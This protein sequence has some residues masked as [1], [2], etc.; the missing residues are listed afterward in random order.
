MKHQ[1]ESR[2]ENKMRPRLTSRSECPALMRINAQM[3]ALEFI[4]EP[5]RKETRLVY[6]GV[7]SACILH[8]ESGFASFHSSETLDLYV[9][10]CR[11]LAA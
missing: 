10:M 11:Q 9:Q 7:D 4:T 1:E 5:V 3:E 6:I 8:F 2:S